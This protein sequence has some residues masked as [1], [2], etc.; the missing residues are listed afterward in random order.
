MSSAGK[1][2]GK[3]LQHFLVTSA[4]FRG[5]V[6]KGYT[7]TCSN[8]LPISSVISTQ[9]LEA[10]LSASVCCAVRWVCNTSAPMLQKV[11]H[12]L[13]TMA[14]YLN[15]S[16]ALQKRRRLFIL[17]PLGSFWHLEHKMGIQNGF[18]FYFQLHVRGGWAGYLAV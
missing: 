5:T 18:S 2:P 17:L 15:R 13:E 4:V 10:C 12:V 6:S 1:L 7:T 16:Q 9:T 11:A 14:V 8:V 3:G